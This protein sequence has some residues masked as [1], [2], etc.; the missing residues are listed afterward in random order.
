MCSVTDSITR[1]FA[2]TAPLRRVFPPCLHGD[3]SK[4]INIRIFDKHGLMKEMATSAEV[5]SDLQNFLNG[6]A[7]QPGLEAAAVAQLAQI[8]FQVTYAN[9]MS[10]QSEI[11]HFG[12]NDFPI[13]LLTATQP[14]QS[15]DADIVSL[16]EQHRIPETIFVV[17]RVGIS[18]VSR[19]TN[20]Y[21]LVDDWTAKPQVLGFG[22]PGPYFL[23]R[24][25]NICR[26]L[27]IIKMRGEMI[28]NI[29]PLDLRPRLISVLKHELGHMFG[30]DHEPNTIMDEHYNVNINFPSYS[31]DQLVIVG[32]ALEI[33]RQN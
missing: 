27:G 11:D 12:M 6:L 25:Q 20:S 32:R 17:K 21:R 24:N 33:L 14:L 13:Y 23:Q 15:S 1:L 31:N 26:K 10:T 2:P 29:Q 3:G 22:F 19:Q 5:V 30:N 4:N 9:R 18:Q 7:S 28:E 16:L 8:N